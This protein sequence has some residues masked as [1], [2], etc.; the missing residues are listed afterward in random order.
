MDKASLSFGDKK[1][2][3]ELDFFVKN[4]D[5]VAIV[6][7]NGCGKSTLIK[8][9]MEQIYPGSGLVADGGEVYVGAGIKVGYLDQNLEFPDENLSV[10]EELCRALNIK[11]GPARTILAKFL[12]FTTDIEKQIRILSGGEKTRLKLAILVHREINTLVL[13]EPTNH[14]DIQSRELLEDVLNE[15]SGTIII[16]SH[17]RYFINKTAKS[18]A[19]MNQGKMEIFDGNYDFFQQKLNERKQEKKEKNDA[20]IQDYKSNKKQSNL[21]RKRQRRIQEIEELA[22]QLEEK[23]RKVDE[24]MFSCGSDYIRLQ[25][26]TEAK[27]SLD[28]KLLCLM[29][30]WEELE[31]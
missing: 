22:A 28:E 5:K 14:M 1:V 18:I 2:L 10:L 13:D 20:S 17:D 30:E 11:Q 15:F 8:L 29:E 23:L 9:M 6:G 12:F 24:E 19:Y 25:E 3:C 7:A 4:K 31:Y 21:E 27:K 16:V 26:L